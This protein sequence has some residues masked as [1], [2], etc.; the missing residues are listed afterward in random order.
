MAQLV[1]SS[2]IPRSYT[3]IYE[4]GGKLGN[5][6]IPVGDVS[7]G[8]R[9]NFKVTLE[10]GLKIDCCMNPF[11][12]F[13]FSTEIP[14][15]EISESKV[16]EF[17]NN[18]MHLLIEDIFGKIQRV[19]YQQIKDG[20][21]PVAFHA[22]VFSETFRPASLQA[23]KS[24][25]I[26][27]YVD[28]QKLYNSG[29]NLYVTGRKTE[30]LK[31]VTDYFSYLILTSSYVNQMVEVMSRIYGD[32]VEVEDD[33]GVKE[34]DLIR[35]VMVST[36]QIRKDCSERYG[37]ILQAVSN[38]KHA[39]DFFSG[40]KFGKNQV[41]LANVLEVGLG[42]ERLER[43][44]EYLLPLWSDILIKNLDNLEFMISA[45]FELQESL[46]TRKEEREMKL[47]QA[48]FLVGVIASI[49]TLGAMPGA[50]IELFHP[51]GSVAATGSIVSFKVQDLVSF[52]VSAILFSITL[53][54]I[55]NFLYMKFSG[56]MS[57]RKSGKKA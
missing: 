54:I 30:G 36:A 2:W 21:L 10:G 28:K 24:D 9:L 56:F 15:S 26:D 57:A 27:V 13:T 51:D 52:G 50:Q 43:D 49:L 37:K 38:F 8:A 20:I 40:E 55:F 14:E 17:K 42:F 23:I 29:S 45:R 7:V 53:F 48:I 5:L 1:V 25:N 47:L 33:L 32:I 19:T 34:F 11:G 44:S 18:V 4:I 31:A 6:E 3:H 46:E 12:L 16:F 22:V 39:R 41:A 35:D